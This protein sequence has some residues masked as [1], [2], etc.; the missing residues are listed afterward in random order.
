MSFYETYNNIFKMKSVFLKITL[1]FYVIFLHTYSCLFSFTGAG[2]VNRW[3]FPAVT[4]K[5]CVF[6]WTQSVWRHLQKVAGNAL[7]TRTSGSFLSCHSYLPYTSRTPFITWKPGPTPHNSGLCENMDSG[8][9]T[10]CSRCM[11]GAFF[12]EPSVPTTTYKVIIKSY[13]FNL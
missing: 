4:I 8:S 6:H 5:G 12:N 7:C 3:V 2:K 10:K 9:G 13:V 11:T 1:P